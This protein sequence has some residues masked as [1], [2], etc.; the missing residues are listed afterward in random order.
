M[1]ESTGLFFPSQDNAVIKPIR[2][3]ATPVVVT[4]TN[5][6]GSTWEASKVLPCH[7]FFSP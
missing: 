2:S 1:G 4:K 5:Y 3:T 7:I 6:T